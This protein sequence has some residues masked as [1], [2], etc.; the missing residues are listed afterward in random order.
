MDP[1]KPP[2]KRVWDSL[3][4]HMRRKSHAPDSPPE[5]AQPP[6]SA[7][8]PPPAQAP[9]PAAP[10]PAAPAASPP[11]E[12][13]AAEAAALK[14]R[15]DEAFK[16]L[17]KPQPKEDEGGAAGPLPNWRKTGF[18][19]TEEQLAKS[20]D[21][22]VQMAR[23]MD[24]ARQRPLLSTLVLLT[25]VS[26]L[27]GDAILIA[28]R[29]GIDDW[30]MISVDLGRDAVDKFAGWE[31]RGSGLT[32]L[33]GPPG[34]EKE[35]ADP[36]QTSAVDGKAKLPDK[37]LA[38]PKLSGGLAGIIT[39]EEMRNGARADFV[40]GI[41]A[42]VSAGPSGSGAVMNAF[43]KTAADDFKPYM[44]AVQSHLEPTPTGV[45]FG[46]AGEALE[47]FASLQ[48]GAGD[49]TP[50]YGGPDY[51]SI[52]EVPQ[53]VKGDDMVLAMIGDDLKKDLKS[54]AKGGKWKMRKMEHGEK[55]VR[56]ELEG[57][58]LTGNNAVIQLLQTKR[59][60]DQGLRCATCET[61]RRIH[62]TR[63]PFFG[64]EY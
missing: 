32:Y 35:V 47:N 6:P 18:K 14:Q 23:L 4:R 17:E 16:T 9:P 24:H 37:P 20:R 41:D 40:G 39:P 48:H 34:A 42:S 25:A 15:L 33:A 27:V 31:R 13:T 28:K 11:P 38:S 10:P 56:H 53:G 57:M 51:A 26:I 44:P 49:A 55:T 8:G 45:F 3:S 61:E 58:T 2:P 19:L 46:A 7:A 43:V 22:K 30:L 59:S 1:D 50:G 60:T 29:L 63:A 52:Q 21:P 5:T 64:E 12:K 54:Y 36:T 62:N